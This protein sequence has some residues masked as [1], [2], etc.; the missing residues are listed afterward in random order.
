MLNDCIIAKN[1]NGK[2]E[3]DG[4][5]IYDPSIC[6]F[7]LYKISKADDSVYDRLGYNKSDIEARLLVFPFQCGIKFFGDYQL[8]NIRDC[9]GTVSIDE[10]TRMH[11]G[12]F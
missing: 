4:I 1:Y 10:I 3:I 11:K 5:N 7:T 2:I 8:L 9:L 12:E 6:Q